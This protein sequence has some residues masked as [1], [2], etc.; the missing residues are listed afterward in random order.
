M[1]DAVVAGTLLFGTKGEQGKT[2]GVPEGAEKAGEQFTPR[3]LSGDRRGDRGRRCGG[4][5]HAAQQESLAT[6]VLKDWA[7]SLMPSAIVR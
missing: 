6:S 5:A 1:A 4:W 2:G 7:A 3:W